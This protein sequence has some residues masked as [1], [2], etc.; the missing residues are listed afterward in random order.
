MERCGVVVVENPGPEPGMSR[1]GAIPALQLAANQRI[2]HH[3]LDVFEA[4]GLDEVIV[5]PRSSSAT[6]FGSA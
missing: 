6:R 5:D 3:V 2:A 1:P 4:A